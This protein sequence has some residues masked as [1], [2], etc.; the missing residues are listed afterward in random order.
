[1]DI[2]RSKIENSSIDLKVTSFFE[3]P[4]ESFI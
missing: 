4:G 1:M 2:L 3:S